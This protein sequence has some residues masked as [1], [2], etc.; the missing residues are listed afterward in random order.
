MYAFCSQTC[1][2]FL[3]IYISLGANHHILMRYLY[4]SYKGER[5]PAEQPQPCTLTQAYMDV[6][7]S[8]S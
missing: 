1:T 6:P 8:N 3:V 4:Y 5:Q 7:G 2:S